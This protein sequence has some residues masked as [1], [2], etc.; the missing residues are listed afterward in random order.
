MGERRILYEY[1]RDGVVNLRDVE[2]EDGGDLLVSC[3]DLDPDMAQFVGTSDW[4]DG[5]RILAANVPRVH[6]ELRKELGDGGLLDLIVKKFGGTIKALT[7][8]EAWLQERKIP[9][10]STRW[11]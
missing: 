11:E 2:L 4:D 3:H 5:C 9:S 8:F 7:L 1:R 6:E 10:R